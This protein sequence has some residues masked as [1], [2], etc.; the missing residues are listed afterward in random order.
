MTGPQE[1][2]RLSSRPKNGD[3]QAFEILVRRY[4]SKMLRVALRFTR[5][6]ADAEDIVQQSFQKAFVHPFRSC[7]A[8]LSS[9]L[10]LESG[11]SRDRVAPFSTFASVCSAQ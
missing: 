7:C 5:N 11:K 3:G 10:T 9:G 2:R 8:Q 1:T 4:R 6:E